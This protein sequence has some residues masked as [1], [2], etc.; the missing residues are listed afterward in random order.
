MSSEADSAPD[1]ELHFCQACGVSIPQ[2]DIDAGRARPEPDACAWLA[3]PERC[4]IKFAERRMAVP[5]PRPV[6]GKPAPQ[7]SGTYFLGALAL[8][9]VVGATT[10]LLSKELSRE[11]PKPMRDDLATRDGLQQVASKLDQVEVQSRQAF[12]ELKSNDGRQR[13]DLVRMSEKLNGLRQ[14]TTRSQS[15]LQ[16][17]IEDLQNT[18]I[19]ISHRTGLLKE[20][21]ETILREL[22]GLG[23]R[24]QSGGAP[25]EAPVVKD[26][27]AKRT[28]AAPAKSREEQERERLVKDYIAKLR[29]RKASDQMRYNAAVQLGDLK[30]PAAV[31]P[32]IEA[33][34]K[35]SYDLVCRAAAWSLGMFGK[36]AVPAIPAL[37][38]QIG[39][40][41]E[42]V[43]YM[44]ER[45]LGEITKAVMGKAV[46]FNFD[47]TMS[48]RE[49]KKVQKEWEKW[50]EGHRAELLPDG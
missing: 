27:A 39:G 48:L 12:G 32:L 45:A 28:P 2:A 22:R 18:V 50:W 1:I 46:T 33:L 6:A 5:P 21:N 41:Q 7:R 37:I 42:Y 26:D 17:D 31:P 47:P 4:P 8:L 23:D 44:C 11:P 3:H 24:V 14:E 19:T 49:R 30:D 36:D 34:E 43:G 13:D 10:F 16:T 20:N 35:D 15:V 9:Y 29:D 40:K 25:R 38:R